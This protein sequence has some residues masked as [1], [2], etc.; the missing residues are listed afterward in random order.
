MERSLWTCA[1]V[2]A[3]LIAV[4]LGGL[5]LRGGVPRTITGQPD[6]PVA[7]ATVSPCTVTVQPGESIQAAIDA[8]PA[9]AVICLGPGEWVENLR[10]EKS[11]SIRGEDPSVTTVAGNVE[12][13][14]VIDVHGLG[15]EEIVV[16]LSGLGVAHGNVR[17]GGGI[18]VDG[19]AQT[20]ISRCDVSG[21]HYNAVSLF[22]FARSRIDDSTFSGNF[23]NIL[24]KNSSQA[25]IAG[26]DISQNTVGI[27][28]Q[29]TAA[30]TIEDCDISGNS[31]GVYL[32]FSANATITDC[33]V[34][35]NDATGLAVEYDAQAAI[36]DCD[37]S[38]NGSFGIKLWDHA[39]AVI[40]SCTISGNGAIGIALAESSQAEI[41]NNVILGNG[42]FGVSLGEPPCAASNVAL[43][44]VFDGRVAGAGN[45]IPGQS[46]PDANMLGAVCP[47][48]TL[49]FLMTPEGGELDRRPTPTG[50]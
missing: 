41:V 25:V 38:R 5:V 39:R 49:N 36:T 7:S 9:G 11:L 14:N 45:A 50:E 20:T 32:V 35:E 19:R 15:E 44:A 47:A 10:I 16:V 4:G 27:N 21:G 18:L 40:S 6:E 28:L 2:L 13:G 17:Y 22:D 1:A 37:I 26:C 23:F 29:E 43:N 12:Y 33:T 34:S 31:T 48:P 24:L 8:G 3:V 30:A 42:D 46:E